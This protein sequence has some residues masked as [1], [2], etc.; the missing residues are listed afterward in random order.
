MWIFRLKRIFLTA[1]VVLLGSALPLATSLAQEENQPVISVSQAP[2]EPIYG[3]NFDDPEYDLRF[4]GP[5]FDIPYSEQRTQGHDAL[6][7]GL[8]LAYTSPEIRD[9]GLRFAARSGYGF[10]ND[11]NLNS[12]Y[13]SRELRIGRNLERRDFSQPSWYLFVADEDEALIWDPNVT[14]T[15]GGNGAR[16][17]LQDQVEIGDM[18]VGI[19]YDWNGWQTS[20]SYIERKVGTQIGH[21]SYYTDQD[22]VGV[23]LTYR[24]QAP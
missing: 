3:V 15:F 22:F 2:T 19:A 5:T 21:E 4:D 6:F 7:R 24:H 17:N 10:T 13:Q 12:Q 16:F 18:Q 20:L 14:S 23:T 11:G 1:L 9:I 8:D